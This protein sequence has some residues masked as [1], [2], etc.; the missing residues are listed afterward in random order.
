MKYRRLTKV[1]AARVGVSYGAKRQVPATLKRVTS[2]TKTYSNREAHTAVIR[3]NASGKG[4]RSVTK[5]KYAKSRVTRTKTQGGVE[6]I[7]RNNLSPRELRRVLKQA[8]NRPVVLVMRAEF[9]GSGKSGTNGGLGW[10]YG[11]SEVDA[12]ALLE[13]GA[14]RKYER[15]SGALSTPRRYSVVIR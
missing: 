2:S 14:L 3:A 6:V 15:A 4:A 7:T 11:I 8:G 12:D 5:E 10:R 13:E 1:E 9:G